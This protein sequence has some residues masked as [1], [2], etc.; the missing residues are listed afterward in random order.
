MGI[1][2]PEMVQIRRW[3]KTEWLFMELTDFTKIPSTEVQNQHATVNQSLSWGFPWRQSLV[4]QPWQGRPSVKLDIGLALFLCVLVD[5]H[6]YHM[7]G[8]ITECWLAE[9]E[10]I[11]S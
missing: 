11:I 2:K 10:G 3:N 1:F 7:Q 8:K 4:I 9:T 5:K 6:A